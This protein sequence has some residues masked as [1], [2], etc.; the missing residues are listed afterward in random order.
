VEIVMNLGGAVTLDGA[1]FH[2]R[3]PARTVV[4]PPVTWADSPS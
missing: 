3:Q 2:G 4:G 1:A